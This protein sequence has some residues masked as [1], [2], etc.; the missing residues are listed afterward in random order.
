M[1]VEF[2]RIPEPKDG[3]INAEE[4]YKYIYNLQMIIKKLAEKINV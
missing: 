2:P 1:F 4:L 3:Q